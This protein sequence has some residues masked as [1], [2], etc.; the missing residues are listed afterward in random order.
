MDEFEEIRK[1]KME[2]LGQRVEEEPMGGRPVEITDESFDQALKDNPAIVVDFWAPWCMPCLALSPIIEKLAKR[3]AGKV[4]FGKL[5]IDEN[6][7]IA[8]KFGITAI[9][10]LLFFKNGKQMDRV[11][12]MVAQAVLEQKIKKLLG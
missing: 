1:R 2:E 8:A 6:R 7:R 12:G 3:Y 9:P 10:T 5:N 4:V 11:I